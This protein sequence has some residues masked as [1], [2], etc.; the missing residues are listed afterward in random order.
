M[1]D[2]HS[3]SG[4][5]KE[6]HSNARSSRETPISAPF[7][8]ARNFLPSFN[9]RELTVESGTPSISAY[10]R[11]TSSNWSIPDI[12]EISVTLPHLSTAIL[13]DARPMGSGHSAGMDLQIIYENIQR[14]LAEKGMTANKAS[15]LAGNPD[16][17]R[18]IERKLAGKIK[19]NGI[20]VKTLDAL[21][22]ALGTTAEDLKRERQK[23]QIHPVHG[24]RETLQKKIDWLQHQLQDA[25]EE[26]AALEAAEAAEAA[27]GNAKKVLRRKYR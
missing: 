19:G 12:T 18:N 10:R 1:S 17:I 6:N 15:S 9:A 2:G 21:A 14:L 26:L 7:S 16:A 5:F 27:Q 8:K 25:K 3:P 24:V 20:T 22:K 4:Q 11:A 23:I 13:P